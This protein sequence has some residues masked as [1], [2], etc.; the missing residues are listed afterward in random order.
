MRMLPTIPVELLITG[1]GSQAG[2]WTNGDPG[3][4]GN[5]PA[6]W[7]AEIHNAGGVANHRPPVL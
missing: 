3:Y 5:L 6:T 2:P 1:D 7:V 4:T